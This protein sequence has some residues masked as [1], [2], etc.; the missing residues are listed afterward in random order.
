M[1]RVS[2]FELF[3]ILVARNQERDRQLEHEKNELNRMI[4][5]YKQQEQK[6][7]EDVHNKNRRYGNDLLQ[8][9]D[10]NGMQKKMVS[11]VALCSF[12]VIKE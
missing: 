6:E 5:L 10:Y 11:S 9:I 1:T 12:S 2:K 3:L 8:Q 7:R 4:E